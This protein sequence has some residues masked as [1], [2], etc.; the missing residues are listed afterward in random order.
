[1]WK[2]Y[3][4]S[5]HGGGSSAFWDSEWDQGGQILSAA[6]NDRICENQGAIC[7]AMSEA[8]RR[9]RLFLEGGC[10]MANW[11]RYF[12][13]RGHRAMGIDFAANTVARINS[14]LPELDVRRGDVTA[15]DLPDRSVHTYYSG[16]VVEHFEGGPGPA[17]RE[18]RRVIAD[19]GWFFCSVPDASAL[20]SRLLFPSQSSRPRAGEPGV[21]Q[22]GTT[23]VETP[24][25][26]STF[27]QYLFGRDE[28][29]AELER[30]GFRVEWTF[31]CFLLW[32]LQEIPAIRW[33]LERLRRVRA[34]RRDGR[35]ASTQASATSPDVPANG[36]GGAPAATSGAR[37]LIDRV[38][39][40]E[41]TTVPLVGPALAWLLER[42]SNMRMFV[43]R[44]R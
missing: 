35:E 30:A 20:R 17:L 44:P 5:A 28:F 34:M 32:G 42:C 8:V 1:M 43:A 24:P 11:V 16:G 26:G 37:R 38:A 4:R 33:S 2:M 15:L 36:A 27:Y 7:R 18:A 41:D 22:V 12:H 23:S 3:L 13:Q 29:I 25:D 19:D 21:R 39:F 10:G 14:A 40:Q 9:D 31:G 6:D